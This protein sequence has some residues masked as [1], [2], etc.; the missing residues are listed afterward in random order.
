MNAQRTAG[1]SALAALVLTA[2]VAASC[3]GSSEG[4]LAGKSAT[5]IVSL[6]VKALH[7]QKS[8]HFVSKIEEGSSSQ[9]QLG[10]VSR[11]AAA[12]T[13]ESKGSPVVEALLAHGVVYI[14]AG[15]ELLENAL[16]LPATAAAAHAGTWL[17]VDPTDSVYGSVAS[18]LTP[19]SA[20]ELFVPNEPHLRVAGTVTF[21]GHQAVAVVGTPATSPPTGDTATVTL[22]VSVT[23][24]FLPLGATLQVTDPSGK[25]VERDAALYGK[26]NE[27]VASVVPRGSTPLSAV[28]PG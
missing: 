18:A 27:R 8:F 6:A 14:R 7:R 16:G 22:Y 21:S 3:G 23:A 11:S 25:V 28:S 17:A 2:A 9:V 24:P 10:D 15:T 20:I 19:T 5:Q 4:A 12:E 1:A 26:W 13:I